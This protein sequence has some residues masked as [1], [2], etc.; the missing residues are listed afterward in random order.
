MPAVEKLSVGSVPLFF[1]N[2]SLVY[3]S[4]F[5]PLLL[6]LLFSFRFDVENSHSCNT[7]IILP[8][9][10]HKFMHSAATFF[11]HT[12]YMCRSTLTHV[13]MYMD[14][15]IQNIHCLWMYPDVKWLQ[16]KKALPL[17]RRNPSTYF[18]NNIRDIIRVMNFGL[19]YFQE[20]PLG[21][22]SAG[23]LICCFSDLLH[24][25]HIIIT[26]TCFPFHAVILTMGPMGNS[27]LDQ[28]AGRKWIPVKEIKLKMDISKIT[29]RLL[30]GK[31]P[32][33]LIIHYAR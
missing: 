30:C 10:I 18:A 2:N 5:F 17:E 33:F 23:M 12:H 28:I 29:V 16:I 32:S 24:M 15:H 4:F 25:Y 31:R 7:K 13:N 26:T 27:S 20:L 21:K 22:S 19:W 6:L 1:P 8:T 11:M 3:V 14:Q 9:F